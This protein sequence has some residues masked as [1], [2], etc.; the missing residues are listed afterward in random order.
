MEKAI[1]GIAVDNW[2]SKILKKDLSE[3]GF[4]YTEHEGITKDSIILK[5]ETSDVERLEVVVIEADNKAI[6]SKMH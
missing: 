2:K 3:A 4:E 1:V 5:V 6:R